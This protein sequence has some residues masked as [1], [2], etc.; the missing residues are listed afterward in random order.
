MVG[1]DFESDIRPAAALGLSTVWIAPPATE[2]KSR[3]P[4]VPT[5]RLATLSELGTVLEV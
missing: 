3:E 4:G 2:P 1:D 5:T